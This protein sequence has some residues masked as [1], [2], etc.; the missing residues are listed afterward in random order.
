MFFM[1][2]KSY[3]LP[4]VQPCC[5]QSS[6]VAAPLQVFCLL[7]RI[8]VPVHTVDKQLECQIFGKSLVKTQV[9]EERDGGLS[10]PDPFN[11]GTKESYVCSIV[12]RIHWTEGT[13]TMY[14]DTANTRIPAANIS[15]VVSELCHGDTSC[16][17][18]HVQLAFQPLQ[19]SDPWKRVGF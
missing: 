1:V 19:R 7:N 10:F 11:T 5:Q 2:R 17:L 14:T 6:K 13:V 15:H 18:L 12:L 3:Q 8:L 16:I 9:S 4:H